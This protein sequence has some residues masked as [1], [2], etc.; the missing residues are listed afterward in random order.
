MF[1]PRVRPTPQRKLRAARICACVRVK[2]RGLAEEGLPSPTAPAEKLSQ[3]AARNDE[4]WC[5]GTGGVWCAV[6][7]PEHFH[8]G[9][10]VSPSAKGSR[11]HAFAQTL[12][13]N[14]T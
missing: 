9:T 10:D 1:P 13:Q 11:Q 2:S 12:L 8:V 6:L 4:V 14:N 3:R 5:G 7:V